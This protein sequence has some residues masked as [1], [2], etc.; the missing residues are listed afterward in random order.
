[1]KV[2][3]IQDE[4]RWINETAKAIEE[5]E[6]NIL[7]SVVNEEIVH[8][9]YH[10]EG[11]KGVTKKVT[12]TGFVPKALLSMNVPAYQERRVDVGYRA[13]RVPAWLGSFAHEK[14]VIGQR[15]LEVGQAA[16]L[17][18]DIE[19][20]EQKRLYGRAWIN[21]LSNCKAVLGTESGASVC[22]FDGSIQEHVEAFEA[23]HPDVHFDQVRDRFF[24][25][26]DGALTISV[27]SPRC[28]EAAALRTLMILYP[29]KYSGRL[30]AW[31]H[32]VP[33]ERDFSNIKEVLAVIRD[34]SMAEA[35]TER[36]Y[37]E[38]ACNFDNTFEAMVADFDAAIDAEWPLRHFQRV[39]QEPSLEN[40]RRLGRRI[41]TYLQVRQSLVLGARRVV[42]S[43]IKT[44]VPKSAQ[45]AVTRAAQSIWRRLI[46]VA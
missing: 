32:Y 22:D 23:Q 28:F 30:K 33:L 11:L 43:S 14:W 8:K 42:N 20:D 36:A 40:I 1:M 27:I 4:Y 39:R 24:S 7:F 9:I 38:V 37:Q 21:F 17:V 45:P 31:Q 6:F 29:G 13:R 25:Q 34:P 41:E 15:F 26:A 5:C 35:I 10:H 46:K 19:S 16:N 44:I 18:C 3:F 12:L 2:I